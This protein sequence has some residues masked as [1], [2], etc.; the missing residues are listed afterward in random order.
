MQM[1][2]Y[3]RI[4]SFILC[5]LLTLGTGAVLAAQEL[6]VGFIEGR[7]DDAAIQEQ[8]F[9][10]AEIE[11]DIIGAADYN[12]NR[13]SEFD[14]IGIGVVSYDQNEDLK[15]NYKVLNEY[16]QS[17]GYLVTLDFQQDSTWNKNFLPH[18]LELF[19]DDIAEP[20][21]V[22]IIDH[23]IWHT[24]FEITEEHFVGWGAGDFMSDGCHEASAPWQPLLISG[25]WHIVIEAEAGGGIVVFSSLETL[26]SLGR[27]GNEKVAEVMHNLLFWHGPLAVNSENKLTT[28]WGQIKR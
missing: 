14:V 4:G 18:P 24:P 23:P 27:T 8:A 2:L 5:L 17:G 20:V 21:G 22:E 9:T 1:G 6:K 15:N 13:L 11:Y 16:V 3:F 7:G 10:T 12:L 28:T 19:D 25:G 26:Q